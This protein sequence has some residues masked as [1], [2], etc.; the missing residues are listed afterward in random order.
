[1]RFETFSYNIKLLPITFPT[2]CN[3][4]ICNE[5]VFSVSFKIVCTEQKC[6]NLNTENFSLADASEYE[7]ITNK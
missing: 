5:M 2:T 3:K 7:R 4:L 1:M 6:Y